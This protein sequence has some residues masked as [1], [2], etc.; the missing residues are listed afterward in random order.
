MAASIGI[1]L[2]NRE[3]Y[4]VLEEN[5]S[6]KERLVLTTVHDDQTSVQIDLYKSQLKTMA[7]AVY[8]GSLVI[9]DIFPRPQGVPS[10]ELLLS[11]T[12]EG[13][14][15][16]EAV[17]LD[18]RE[19][20]ERYRLNISLASLE[21]NK[22]D[23]LVPDFELEAPA[24]IPAD[25]GRKKFVPI[26]A[27]VLGGVL[28][29][30]IWLGIWLFLSHSS[31]EP[32]VVFDSGQ[33]GTERPVQEPPAAGAVPPEPQAPSAPLPEPPPPSPPE[34]PPE[35]AP[36][37][38]PPL[39]TAPATPPPAAPARSR[40][41]PVAPVTRYKIPA[42]IPAGGIPYK[43]QWG[44]TLWEISE[45]FYRNPWL[46]PRIARFNNIRNPNRIISGTTIRIPPR[47]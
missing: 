2:A 22:E 15:I 29:I 3:F 31:Q 42:V 21:D 17:D 44:D 14:I 34:P 11:A 26:L 39:I 41:R 7:D 40:A 20:G 4:P 24:D 9:E 12:P 46:Y 25:G 37:T 33:S 28:V 6:G 36:R 8:I 47:N 1:K 23:I 5:S 10:V 30:L 45:A 27:L 13:E 35:P 18:A 43:I 16:A 19:G 38:E 32:P